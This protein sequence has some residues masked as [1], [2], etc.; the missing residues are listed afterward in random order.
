MQLELCFLKL[1]FCSFHRAS[2]DGGERRFFTG[3]KKAVANGRLNPI[4][5]QFAMDGGDIQEPG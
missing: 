2:K 1:A 4:A 3:C 5:S